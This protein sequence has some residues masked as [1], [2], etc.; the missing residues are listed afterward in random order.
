M[1]L[2]RNLWYS[3]CIIIYIINTIYFILIYNKNWHYY[4][5]IGWL[6][7]YYIQVPTSAVTQNPLR[8]RIGSTNW[9]TLYNFWRTAYFVPWVE[10]DTVHHVLY[11]NLHMCISRHERA[12][13]SRHLGR[14]D[15]ISSKCICMSLHNLLISWNIALTPAMIHIY[16]YVFP[17]L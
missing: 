2:H 9:P 6:M 3:N 4:C 16:I 12:E 7:R 11:C 5:L 13:I 8:Q 10:L 15:C 1:C 17:F 14:K